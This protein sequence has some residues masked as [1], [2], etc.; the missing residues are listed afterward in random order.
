MLFCFLLIIIALFRDDVQLYDEGSLLLLLKVYTQSKGVV[1]LYGLC[2]FGSNSPKNSLLVRENSVLS[3][4][5]ASFTDPERFHPVEL[6]CL[7]LKATTALVSDVLLSSK[8]N[9][10]P[11][12]SLFNKVFEVCGG[13]PF[14][15]YEIAK[16]IAEKRESVTDMKLALHSVRV[17]EV[18]CHRFDKLNYSTQSFLKIAAVACSNGSCF[19]VAMLAEISDDDT[20]NGD[21]KDDSSLERNA[22][23]LLSVLERES[24]LGLVATAF[25]EETATVTSSGELTLDSLVNGH[26]QFRFN[27]SLEQSV[28]YNLLLD[29]QKQAIHHSIADY[30]TLRRQKVGGATSLSLYREEGYHWENALVYHS[31]MLCYFEAFSGDED[32]PRNSENL[33][34][35][36]AMYI[37]LKE[38][39]EVLPDPLGISLDN[40]H[41]LIDETFNHDGKSKVPVEDNNESNVLAATLKL[42][43]VFQLFDGDASMLE[44]A[45][46]IMLEV[47]LQRLRRSE[48]SVPTQLMLENAIQMILLTKTPFL[49]SSRYLA[50]LVN[51]VTGG[52]SLVE[53]DM[54]FCLYGH[55]SQFCLRAFSAYLLNYVLSPTASTEYFNKAQCVGDQFLLMTRAGMSTYHLVQALCLNALVHSCHNNVKAMLTCVE[56]LQSLYVFADHSRLLIKMYGSDQ[57]IALLARVAKHSLLCGDSERSATLA[58]ACIKYTSMTSDVPTLLSCAFQLVAVLSY[59]DSYVDAQ[60]LWCHFDQTMQAAKLHRKEQIPVKVLHM[61][62]EW[63]SLRLMNLSGHCNSSVFGDKME[64][65]DEVEVLMKADQMVSRFSQEVG[66]VLADCCLMKILSCVRENGTSDDA[67]ESWCKACCR[68]LQPIVHANNNASV[69]E[70]FNKATCV[71]IAN[72]VAKCLAD[73][74]L[75]KRCLQPLRILFNSQLV[76]QL[77]NEAEHRH[78]QSLFEGLAGL[79]QILH[80]NV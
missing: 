69:R 58:N 29:D 12:N 9:T 80:A 55:F 46:S 27:V 53:T 39:T 31:A 60:M 6:E 71:K 49:M 43:R 4:F 11:D 8:A 74:S 75:S 70:L 54:H 77:R 15:A 10:P 67:I 14:Y 22:K 44:I 35:A 1:V 13:N 7:N 33:D 78:L 48:G 47:S 59:S 63:L 16:A 61:Y 79:Y 38:S 20:L 73:L 25:T 17:E 36:F 57:V 19:T 45:L 40:L 23:I 52:V 32:V 65:M 18:I 66:L 28:I 62:S 68:H 26:H 34:K 42:E 30:L 37:A 56:E 76:L 50:N 5:A 64:L 24:F 21:E 3:Q 2:T 41:N 72:E 51:S